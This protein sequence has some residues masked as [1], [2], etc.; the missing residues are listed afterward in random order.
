MLRNLFVVPDG[1]WSSEKPAVL[2]LGVL[3][4]KAMLAVG[5]HLWASTGGQVFIIS[6]NTHCV[7]VRGPARAAITHTH[8]HTPRL[9]PTHS[10]LARHCVRG[11]STTCVS[12]GEVRAEDSRISLQLLKEPS[13]G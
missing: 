7:E 1:L 3:P 8:T 5:E 4:V 12:V 10:S 11:V 2:K 13:I 9:P 6:A